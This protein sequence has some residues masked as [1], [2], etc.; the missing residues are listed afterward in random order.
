MHDD[1]TTSMNDYEKAAAAAR[2][3]IRA[4]NDLIEALDPHKHETLYYMDGWCAVP[5]REEFDND[6]LHETI[7]QLSDFVPYLDDLARGDG[8]EFDWSYMFQL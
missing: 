8:P 6:D 1:P 4:L 3:A 2:V 7:E 5:I